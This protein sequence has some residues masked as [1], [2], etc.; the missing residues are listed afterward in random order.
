MTA[1][2]GADPEF[3]LYNSSGEFIAPTIEE[4]ADPADFPEDFIDAPAGVEVVVPGAFIV[5]EEPPAIHAPPR[6]R[7]RRTRRTARPRTQAD[8]YVAC[9]GI[10]PG[11]KQEPHVLANAPAD[12]FVCHEDNVCLEVGIPPATD[13]MAFA[14]NIQTVRKL[15]EEEFLERQGLTLLNYPSIQFSPHQLLSK[16]AKNFG[17]EPDYNAYASGAV[18]T[19]DPALVAGNL[20]FAGGHIHIG[21]E[22][23]CPPFVAALFADIFLS[24]PYLATKKNLFWSQEWQ[25]RALWYGQPGIFRAKPYGIEYRT[26]SNWWARGIDNASM[27]GSAALSLSRFLSSTS[28]TRLRTAVR[29]ID[30]LGLQTLLSTPPA[31]PKERQMKAMQMQDDVSKFMYGAI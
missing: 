15:V 4:E 31:N 28:A 6:N 1:T 8:T 13:A 3:F 23:N 10:I 7:M 11:T 19:I 5:N 20:R 27:V 29:N 25:R 30:W 12:G 17:C 26:P 18:R 24:L 22:F 16:Q 14:H 21:G 2:V 9:V